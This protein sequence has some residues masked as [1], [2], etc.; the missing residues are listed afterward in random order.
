M[1]DLQAEERP[2]Q[3]RRM[4]LVCDL[5]VGLVLRQAREETGRTVAVYARRLS[6]PERYLNALEDENFSVLPGLVYEKHFVAIYADALH[7]D[8]ERLVDQWIQ[9]REGEAKPTMKFVP[10]VARSDFWISPLAIRRA[11]VSLV[12]LV[13]AGYVGDRL[14]VMIAPPALEVQ[15]PAE[16]E[17]TNIPTLTITGSA[18]T[19]AAVV[20][21]GARVATDA[22]GGFSVPVTLATGQNVIRVEASRRF[23]RTALIQRDVFLSDDH[24][25]TQSGLPSTQVIP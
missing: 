14:L 7:L 21:N 19:D 16:S 11:L 4:A 1:N 24:N 12:L 17:V 8:A 5:S 22:S 25:L 10:R 6:I 2:G 20:V 23:G 9:L 13:V 3:F 18:P 15:N